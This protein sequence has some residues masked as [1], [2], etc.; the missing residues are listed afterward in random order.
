ML[1]HQHAVVDGEAGSLCQSNAGR[2]PDADHH[3]IGIEPS[4]VVES[5][6][7][8]GHLFDLPADMPIDAVVPMSGGDQLGKLRA[9]DAAIGC[10]SGATTDT[11]WPRSRSEAAASSPMK[12]P[13]TT[14]N[15][16]PPAPRPGCPA[17]LER[18]QE[19]H[20][21]QLGAGE[22]WA[23]WPGASGKQEL[24][25]REYSAVVDR[26]LRA[27]GSMRA[28]FVRSI[29]RT[30]SSEKRSRLLSGRWSSPKWPSR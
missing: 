9:E 5:H 13:P 30:R 1:V 8:L 4:A 3:E 25:I 12:L 15:V 11:L 23:P 2:H 7:E 21:G 22:I 19:L 20:M 24:G 14:A 17:V 6:G 29:S 18:A 28:I 27:V 26:H 10:F 16:A